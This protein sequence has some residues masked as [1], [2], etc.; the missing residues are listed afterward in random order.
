MFRIS[1]SDA[2]DVDCRGRIARTSIVAIR[3]YQPVTGI[4]YQCPVRPITQRNCPSK[5]WTGRIIGPTCP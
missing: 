5:P 3:P 4:A 2:P 1:P